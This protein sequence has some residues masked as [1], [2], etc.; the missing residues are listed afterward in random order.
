MAVILMGIVHYI[1]KTDNY[2]IAGLVLSFPGLS[3]LAYYFMYIEQGASKV[4]ETIYFAIV[5]AIPFVIFLLVLNFTLK[6]YNIFKSIL[7]SSV[8]WGFFA[9]ILIITWKNFS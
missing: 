7:I 3:I 6:N 2:Y 8:V 4:R 5:S 1:S 9:S